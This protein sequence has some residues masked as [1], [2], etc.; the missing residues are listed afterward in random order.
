V[1]IKV[2]AA[3][4]PQQADYAGLQQAWVEAEEL[5]VDAIFNWDHFYPLYG[6]PDG[7]HFECLTT[8]TAMAMV[9]ERVQVGSLVICNS[10]RNPQ[11]LAD[12]LRTIDHI[13]GGRVIVGIGAGWFR[14]DYD[15]YGYE[16]GTAPSRLKDLARDLPKL[17]ERLGKLNPPPVGPM[18]ILIGG[19]G[20]QV[21]L[22][23]VAQ[24]ADMWHAFGDAETFA[25]KSGILDDWCAKLGRDPAAVERT[26]AVP[27]GRVDTADALREAGATFFIMGFG[28]NGKGYDLAPLRD[29]VAWRDAQARVTAA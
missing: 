14:R 3:I 9:T 25:R 17:K 23:I 21:T 11:Y 26:C 4:Q 12:A 10:Y 29:L 27:A 15:E 22:R 28:G 2:G 8:L 7:Q 13:A 18:P 20:E 6:D 16:F 24:H 1:A 19:G 5:G